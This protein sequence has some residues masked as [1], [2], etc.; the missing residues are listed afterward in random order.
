MPAHLLWRG[1]RLACARHAKGNC[2]GLPGT[3][4]PGR[5]RGVGR[6]SSGIGNAADCL[7]GGATFTDAHCKGAL[8]LSGCMGV[9]SA[10]FCASASLRAGR[11][12]WGVTSRGLGARQAAKRRSPILRLWRSGANAWLNLCLADWAAKSDYSPLQPVWTKG[13]IATRL[14]RNSG[15]GCHQCRSRRGAFQRHAAADRGFTFSP[16]LIAQ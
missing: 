4:W 2:C 16:R 11:V 5:G 12:G 3:A 1:L 8:A 14:N 7:R 10:A 9:G 6:E 15:K 13:K